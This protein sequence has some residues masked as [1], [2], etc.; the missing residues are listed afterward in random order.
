MQRFHN[1]FTTYN[2]IDK[3]FRKQYLVTMSEE[4][5]DAMKKGEVDKR[6]FTHFEWKK[7]IRI[8]RNPK[9]AG[10]WMAVSMA[11]RKMKRGVSS[12]LRKKDAV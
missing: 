1:Y 11:A 9:T 7:M 2:R 3:K 6:Y 4:L 5:R 8:A 10:K 12:L